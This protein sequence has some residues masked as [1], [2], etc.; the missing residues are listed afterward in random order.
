MGPIST[1]VMPNII[2]GS[3]EGSYTWNDISPF[4]LNNHTSGESVQHWGGRLAGGVIHP[5][6]EKLSLSAEVGGGYYGSNKL[7][8]PLAGWNA[9]TGIDG[10]DILL[11]ALYKL[12]LFDIFGDVGFMAQNQRV[13]VNQQLERSLPGGLFSGQTSNKFNTT[14]ILPEIKVG[15]I[16]NLNDNWGIS[17][18]Y[19]HV[20]GSNLQNTT[21][22]NAAPSSIVINGTAN[23]ENT[24]L[25]AIMLGL[26]YSIA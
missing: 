2:F 15:G 20:F 17:L 22:I 11:G 19:I 10:Y 6:T 12:N 4:K 18:A 14:Q 24:T 25:N 9:N 5:V 7:S 1:S 23:V 26:R 3:I 21:R 8:A 16:Y 13:H